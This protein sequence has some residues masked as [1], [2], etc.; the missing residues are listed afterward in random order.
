[1]TARPSPVAP[2]T[3]SEEPPIDDAADAVREAL[4]QLLAAADAADVLG[5]P[6]DHVRAA[7]G[8]ASHRLGFPSDAYVLALV[9]GTGVG[10]SSLLNA[11]AG[12]TVSAASARRPTTSDPIA[13]VPAAELPGLVPVLRWL[14]VEHIR[15]HEAD[16]LGPV[17]ILDLPDMDSVTPAHRARVEALLPRVD[18]V[19]WVTDLE[20][21]AD[22]VLHDDF[23]RTWV[24]RLGR[25][26]VVVNKVDRLPGADRPR[27]RRDLEAD[28]E[29]RLPIGEAHPVPV[30]MTT[31]LP[32]A[33]LDELRSWLADGASAKAIARGRVRATV[34]DLAGGLARDAGIEPG[35]PVTPFL[36]DAARS[37]AIDAASE[38]VLRA[39][40]LEGLER[41]AVAATRARARAHGAGP[42]GGLTSLVYRLSG[43][44]TKVASPTG[45]LMRWR[46]HGPLTPAVEAL[47]RGLESSLA[48]ASPMVRPTLAAALEPAPLRQGLERAVDQAVA[49]VG[50]LEAPTS[51]W[52]SV[53]GL[54]QT[55]ATLAIAV[56]AAWVVLWVMTR[57]PVE[58]VDLPVIG[59]VPMPFVALVVTLLVGYVLARILGLHAGWVGRRW[60]RRVRERVTTAV[61][62]EVTGRGLAP[63]D[64]LEDARRRLAVAVSA[65][66][67]ES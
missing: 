33:E 21:Y 28:L 9:G 4:A 50:R 61:R 38:A 11:L 63:L 54:L 41:Q 29:R 25:Q 39:V 7:L 20:K 31:A 45:F 53:L 13:W 57:T 22:A 35:R 67:G 2:P 64:D 51:R 12:S 1:M 36:S 15:E 3:S 62:D 49:G 60:A 55:L 34:D 27:V 58:S 6:T 17:A 5:I 23:L 14:E 47:R 59:L 66:L 10:K 40:D 44:E 30:L 43:R 32:T 65:I 16:G 52:W 42:L 46:D 37:A 48:E 18:A 24:P 19:V 8:D 26:A 56:S